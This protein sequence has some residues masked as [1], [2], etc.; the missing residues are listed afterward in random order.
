[1]RDFKS[2]LEKAGLP[3]IR[4]HDLRHSC[5]SLLASQGVSARHR[6]QLLGHSDVRLTENVYTHPLPASLRNAV[7]GL[8]TILEL[9]LKREAK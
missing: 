1:V 7:D 8:A 3:E 2:V 5:N 6:A 9:P 4:F